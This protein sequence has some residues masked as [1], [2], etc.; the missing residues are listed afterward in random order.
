MILPVIDE[1]KISSYMIILEYICDKFTT[2][3][4]DVNNL[5]SEILY[6]PAYCKF[7]IK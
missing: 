1:L 6:S 5:S 4:D 2:L 3:P 7:D